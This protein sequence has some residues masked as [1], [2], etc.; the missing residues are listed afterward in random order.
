MFETISHRFEDFF[1]WVRVTQPWKSMLHAT[2]FV[3]VLALAMTLIIETFPFLLVAGLL[4]GLFLLATSWLKEF[5]FLMNLRDD[6]FQGHN[7]KL[8]WA[9]LMIVLPPVGVGVF[10]SY[11]LQRW[12]AAKVPTCAVGDLS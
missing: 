4:V 9:I 10:R 2:G 8:I 7:D 11:R 3:C 12:P 6:A 5:R 1:A